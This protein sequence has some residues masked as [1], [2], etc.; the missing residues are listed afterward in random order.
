MEEVFELIN[1]MSPFLLLGFLLAGIMH[2]FIPKSIYRNFLGKKSIKSVINAAVLGVPLPLCSCGTIP[3]AMSLRKD[4]ASK[5]ATIAFLVST[6]QTGI[7]SIIAT[8]SL[9]GLP[10]ALLRPI[11][12]FFT[13]LVGG[14][15]VNR[16][17]DDDF[18]CTE[19]AGKA[20]EEK[21]LSFKEKIVSAQHYAFVEMIQ[22]IGKWL[23]VGLL[24][25]GLI[26][27]FVPESFFATFADNSLLSMLFVLLLS[28]PMY[29]CATGS[30]PIAVALM[31]KGLSPGTALVLLMAGPAINAASVLVVNKVMGRKTLVIYLLSIVGG[32]MFFG[33][34]TDYFLPTEWFT[35]S[36]DK[37][38]TCH[39]EHTSY[40]N[41]LCTILMIILLVNAM[42][43]RHNHKCCHHGS[44]NECDCHNE[45]NASNLVITI[46]GMQ[47]NHC[48]KNVENAIRQVNPEVDIDID[49]TTGK[50]IISGSAD[51]EKTK[52]AIEDLGFKIK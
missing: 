6:P 21:K 15:L 40:F 17:C 49:L 44:G 8:Y 13:A 2:A 18:E 39:G 50:T 34:L 48:K 19:E 23:I 26:T 37:I 43:K 10:F 31:L 45:Q 30:I 38:K 25:A 4:G 11:A 32:A 20:A 24:F 12:A 5:G 47:C 52:K 35:E 7:D 16:F 14:I 36:I 46:E 29:I 3:T 27:I 1:E 41:I 33:L 22:D 51:I 28:L 42:I 9:I